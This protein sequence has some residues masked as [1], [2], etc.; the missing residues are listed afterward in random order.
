MDVTNAFLHGDLHDQVYMV[1]TPGLMKENDKC[2]CRLQKSLY[3]LHQTS[4]E[5]LHKLFT[6]LI[7]FDFI[8]SLANHSLFTLTIGNIFI[9]ILIYADNIIIISKILLSNI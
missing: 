8:Q 9:V 5:W 4:K 6:I 7:E 3:R 1:P 2:V